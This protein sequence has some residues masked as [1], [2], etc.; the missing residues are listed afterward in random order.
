MTSYDFVRIR[1][2]EGSSSEVFQGV[3][4]IVNQSSGGETPGGET[5]GGETPPDYSGDITA[6]VSYINQITDWQGQVDT[7]IDDYRGDVIAL[8]PGSPAPALPA[9]PALPGWDTALMAIIAVASPPLAG[10]LTVIRILAHVIQSHKQREL[11]ELQVDY[12]R[13]STLALEQLASTDIEFDIQT[14][15]VGRV[16][17]AWLRSGVVQNI[18]T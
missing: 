16:V 17:R 2:L 3:G 5:P 1:G 9:L 18:V 6:A 10:A 12:Q 7:I 15:S 14:D 13:R 11:Q 8:P 4:L